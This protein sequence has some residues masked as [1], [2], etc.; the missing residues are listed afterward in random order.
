MSDPLLSNSQVE[1]KELDA[2]IGWISTYSSTCC[3]RDVLV[4]IKPSELSGLA[5]K[6]QRQSGIYARQKTNFTR[7]QPYRLRELEEVCR[8]VPRE[9]LL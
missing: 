2:D 3:Y 5:A 8:A 6:S 4:S 9:E 1:L 7:I